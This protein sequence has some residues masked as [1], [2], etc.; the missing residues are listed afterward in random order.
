MYSRCSFWDRLWRNGLT[1]LAIAFALGPILWV[2][3]ASF[4]PANTIVGQPLIPTQL[5]LEH[6]RALFSDPRHPFHLWMWNSVKVAVIAAVLTVALT[7]L[8]AYAFSRFRF[9]GRRGGLF[10]LI[11]IQ[12]FPQML[13]MVAIYLL[14]LEIGRYL[15]WLGLNTHLGLIMVYLG[16]AMGVNTWLM[17]GYFDT[18]PRSLEESAMMD[19]ASHLQAFVHIILPL[20]RPILTVVFMLSLIGQYSEY[21]LARVL[22]QS[23][24]RFTL[25]VGMQLFIFNQYD[26]RWGIFAAGAI[27]GA[28]PIV[29]IFLLVQSQLVSGLTSGAVK[30]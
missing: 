27:L 11:L 23:T 18:I 12:M 16:G 22:L 29:I 10:T 19:G 21:I 9:Q 28:I 7:A 15:P 24:D 8:G 26:S 30:E 14:L 13:A 2:F 6:Y 1:W 20:V 25:P 17:K 3:S 4:S 5:S